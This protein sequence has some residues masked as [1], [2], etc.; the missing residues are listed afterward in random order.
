MCIKVDLGIKVEIL[1]VILGSWP[2][3]AEDEPF[4]LYR[5]KSGCWEVGYARHHQQR[6]SEKNTQE[7]T[8]GNFIAAIKVLKHLR[9]Y[10]GLDTVS[11]HLECLLYSLPDDLFRGNP[12]AY[13]ATILH[14]LADISAERCYSRRGMRRSIM[15]PCGER[16]LFSQAEWSWESWK[17]FHN[18]I[19]Y[20]DSLAQ[21]ACR[22]PDQARAIQTWQL[23]LGK[24]FFPSEVMA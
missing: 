13:I 8:N 2:S 10:Y 24:D 9:S 21:A 7:R 22:A 20:F 19:M 5:P 16:R 18:W 15:T 6:L 1:P 23:L 4:F 3:N 14:A 12:A 11:F 17:A